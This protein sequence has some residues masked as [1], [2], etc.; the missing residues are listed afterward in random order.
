MAKSKKRDNLL[1]EAIADAKQVRETALANA[2]LAL[3]EA[4]TPQLTSMLA[5]KLRNEAE[6]ED[7]LE[8]GEEPKAADGHG[9]GE[10]GESDMAAIEEPT[11]K[12]SKGARGRRLQEAE[13]EDEDLDEAM[14]G[15]EPA[16]DA[17]VQ[18][19]AEHLKSS[20]I[21]TESPDHTYG[22]SNPKDPQAKVRQTSDIEN[23]GLIQGGEKVAEA[24]DPT[25]DVGDG[26]SD[27][28][29][30][31]LDAGAEGDVGAVAPEMDAGADLEGGE[32]GEE[33]RDM[34]LEA[35]IRELEADIEGDETDDVVGEDDVAPELDAD[36]RQD[37]APEDE[38]PTEGTAGTLQADP[39]ADGHGSDEGGETDKSATVD[40]TFKES[41]N[42]KLQKEAEEEDEVDLEEILR[43]IEDEEEE[44]KS[45]S[46]VAGLT[47]ELKE[48]RTAVKFLR[49]KL[50]EVNLLNAKLLYTNRLFRDYN[51]DVRSKMRVVENFDR[52][53]TVREAKL[54]YA[55]IA[56]SFRGKS[57]VTR[58]VRQ[59]I[60][61]GLASRKTGSTAPKTV[62][63]ARVAE[64]TPTILREG[65]DLA[66]RFQKLAGIKK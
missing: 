6:D 27:E 36:D 44:E 35:I 13:D 38:M 12:E 53:T 19:D 18:G 23:A 42:A 9:T 41:K 1:R 57:G 21:G 11:F 26:D 10:G 49:S 24:D 47:A 59:S 8:E 4:F 25:L 33:G 63:R 65:V 28:D 14:G 34:D 15:T 39:V 50:N 45:E 30:L 52:A 54:V 17:G 37:F 29:D 62:V 48:Y 32:E 20:D 16:T 22:T 60:T 56:E 51:M 2:K 3:E 58:K 31:G 43:E 5:T 55:T 46:K 61:E 7:D 66:R 40:P 64:D